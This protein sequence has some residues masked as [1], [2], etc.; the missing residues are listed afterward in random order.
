MVTIVKRPR[1]E[2]DLLDIW[3]YI[4]DDSFDRADE[5]LDRVE[6]KLQTLARNPGLGRRRQELLPGLQSFP[7]G[8]YVVFYR[9]IENGI[10]VI[11]ILHGSRDIEDIFSR[12]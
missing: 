7:L 5:F 9:E 10:E 12:D 4:A 6:I 3:D 1:A 11:R 2:Q 8:N